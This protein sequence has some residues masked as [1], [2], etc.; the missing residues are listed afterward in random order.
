MA[1][2]ACRWRVTGPPQFSLSKKSQEEKE[3]MRKTFLSK[4]GTALAFALFVAGLILT[5]AF[6]HSV[7][8][9]V[10]AKAVDQESVRKCKLH[11]A[12]GTYGFALVGSFAAIG[13]VAT[14]G[15]TNFDGEGHDVGKFAVTTLG[16]TQEFTF[17]GTYTVNADCT[18]T[19]TLNVS[20]SVFGFSV[21]HFSAVGTDNDKEIKWLITDPGIIIAGTLTKQ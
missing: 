5:L 21:L 2:T 1:F 13:P 12:T 6:R 18:G 20:P 4:I 9:S 3:K 17:S 7:S 11:S 10:L 19:A 14:S 16:A 15:T 8:P